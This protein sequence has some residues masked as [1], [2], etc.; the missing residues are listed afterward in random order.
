LA[1]VSVPDDAAASQIVR[2]F[3]DLN[4]TSPV[5]VRCRYL[6]NV[7][8]TEKAGA[9]AVVSEEEEASGALLALC[10]KIVQTGDGVETLGPTQIQ[11][12]RT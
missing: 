12:R 11:K 7:G 6:A 10:E 3:R 5:I 1:V 2:T 4:P 9:N 8:K